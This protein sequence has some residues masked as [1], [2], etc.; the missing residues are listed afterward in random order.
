MGDLTTHGFHQTDGSDLSQGFH[1]GK[2]R[3]TGVL[4]LKY[5]LTDPTTVGF[6]SR[7]LTVQADSYLWALPQHPKRGKFHGIDTLM[8]FGDPRS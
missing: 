4:T 6:S 8:D 1:N 7:Y 2:S 3:S 5:L